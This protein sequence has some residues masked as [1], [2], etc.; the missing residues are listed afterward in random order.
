MNPFQKWK[1]YL[2][3]CY[4]T[5]IVALPWVQVTCFCTHRQT[6]IIIDC[7]FPLEV[8]KVFFFPFNHRVS[9]L[10]V[11]V[12]LYSCFIWHHWL[13]CVFMYLCFIDLPPACFKHFGCTVFKNSYKTLFLV[14]HIDIWDFSV[15][16]T[17]IRYKASF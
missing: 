17:F 4:S 8:T 16:F 2:F 5:L 1:L 14:T 6:V 7:P 15:L 10:C 3:F 12:C 9:H 11:L 13:F